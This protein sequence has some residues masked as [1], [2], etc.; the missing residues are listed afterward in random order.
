MDV[1]KRASEVLKAQ[2]VAVQGLVVT[3][4]MLQA[5]EKMAGMKATGGR[6][7]TT[8]MGKAG[9]VATKMSATLASI[10]LPSFFV[11][12]AEAA[13]GDVGRVAP[14]DLVIVF[15]HSGSTG[16]VVAMIETLHALNGKQNVVIVIGSA[17]KP[18]IPAS[19]VVSYGAIQESCIVS[20][21]P[22]TSTTLMLVIAD[23]LAIAAAESIGLDDSWF[24]ARH[25]GGAIGH[26]YKGE[27]KPSLDGT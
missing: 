27:K 2:Q 12:P 7:I 11:S 13:H 19:I 21:V 9:I 15:S 26:A 17:D 5:I 22:S 25:P 24:K 23:V 10:G 4:A 8:G 1:Q 14:E 16:E 3:P 6:I 20:K 18:K